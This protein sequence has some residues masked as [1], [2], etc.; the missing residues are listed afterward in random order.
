MQANTITL[1][2]D[3][4]NNGTLVDKD[5]TRHSEEVNKTVYNGPGHTLQSRN[6]M[7]LYR[8]LPKRVGNFLGSAKTSIKFT[9]DYAVPGADGVNGTVPAIL[10]VD[11]SLPVGITAAQSLE[12]RQHVVAAL[13]HAFAAT[14]NDAQEI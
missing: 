12:L 5:Y 8:T 4:L 13:D 11:F 14:L 2:V 1:P 9:R 6:T 7:T 3:V 10:N